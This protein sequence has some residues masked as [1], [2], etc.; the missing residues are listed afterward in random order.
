MGGPQPS[1]AED[2][3]DNGSDGEPVPPLAP[4]SEY[5]RAPAPAASRERS[6]TPRARRVA[7]RDRTPTPPGQIVRL[8]SRVATQFAIFPELSAGAAALP[9]AARDLESAAHVLSTGDAWRGEMQD[10]LGDGYFCHCTGQARLAYLPHTAPPC[11]RFARSR[12]SDEWGTVWQLRSNAQPERFSDPETEAASGL[13][14]RAAFLAK[15]V[16]EKGGH[17]SIRY[18]RD[19][20]I[21]ERRCVKALLEFKSVKLIRRDACRA[22]SLRKK[23]T[24][25]LTNAPW[26][27]DLP[28]DMKE[29]P[30]VH[31][32]LEGKVVD[33]RPEASQKTV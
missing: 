28:R 11:Q 29:R 8:V 18:S 2:D 9:A 27:T 22:G 5:E 21:G 4:D 20:R 23:P 13:A 15:V 24:G 10:L 26:I 3:D 12:R 33:H 25:F 31:V 17:F 16:A 1:N 7:T 32:P 30:Y 19:S 6:P 14:K